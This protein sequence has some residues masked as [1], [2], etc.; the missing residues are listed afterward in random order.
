[1]ESA[2]IGK[3]CVFLHLGWNTGCIHISAMNLAG[4]VKY[5]LRTLRNSPGFAAVAIGT[6][7]LGIGANTV[8]FTGVESFLLRPLPL[9]NPESLVF[10]HS[11]LK[12]SGDRLMVAYPD[13]LDWKAAASAFD[14]LGGMQ[15]DTFNVMQFAKFIDKLSKTKDGDGTLLDRSIMMFGSSLSDGDMHSPLELPTVL[16]GGGNGTLRGNE[17]HQWGPDKKMPMSNL[18][19]TLLDKL[20]VNVKKVGDSTGDLVEL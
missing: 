5:A 7:A 14:N 4:D 20:G 19:V 3:A 1:M 8:V 12:R 15:I 16:A 18:Y 2:P 17:H 11:E 10:V 13:L 9:K 6:L